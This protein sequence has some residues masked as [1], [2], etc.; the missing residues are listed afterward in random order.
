MLEVGCPPNASPSAT[1]PASEPV[2]PD[3]RGSWGR[4]TAGGV[5]GNRRLTTATAVLLLV[6]LAVEGVTILRL[7]LLL[8]VHMF[9]GMLLI[10][11]VA[12]KMASTGYRF[13]RYYAASARY[14]RH[15]P[16]PP[17]LRVI[18]PMLVA[19]TVT[20]LATGVALMLLG[21]SSRHPVLTLH[22][23]SFIVWGAVATL[24][25]L[26]H[27]PGMR[28]PLRA[29]YAAKTVRSSEEGRSGRVL[30]LA[31][32]LIA[33]ALLA[34]LTIPMYGPWLNDLGGR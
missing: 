28:A 30:A 12:L 9:V 19:S 24:H 6:L 8:S 1:G 26:G 11:P 32:A 34:L 18:A 15:G 25:V 23:A 13:L 17:A 5:E 22:K 7:R 14:R 4:L 16:P 10:P 20:V 21:P 2:A 3:S 27:L 31:G 33:G 29:D